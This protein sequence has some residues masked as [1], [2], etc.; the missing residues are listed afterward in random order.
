M[1]SAIGWVQV[2]GPSNKFALGAGYWMERKLL[3]K[4][5]EESTAHE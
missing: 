2:L 5:S 4:Q 1:P 3:V